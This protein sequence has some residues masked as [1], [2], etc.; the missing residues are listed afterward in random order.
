MPPHDLAEFYPAA[1]V[2]QVATM[3]PRARTVADRVAGVLAWLLLAWTTGVHAQQA[4]GAASDP[5]VPTLDR[6][7]ALPPE[8]EV[9]DL[10]RFENPVVVPPNAF[11]RAYRPAPSLEEISLE[12][13]GL[14]QY[15]I[16]LG[17]AKS[18]KGIKEVTGMRPQTQAVTAR[19][20][21]LD[22]R[23]LRRAVELCATAGID[24]ADNE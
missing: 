12:H 20:P 2:L 3:N 6:V 18:W 7:E 21:P 14:I 13:G 9:L 19:P 11:A 15:G 24:C 5:D 4:P 10:Y 23:Q 17:L 8:E 22:E 1:G 16:N